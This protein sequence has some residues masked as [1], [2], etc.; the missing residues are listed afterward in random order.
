[1]RGHST[2]FVG[3]GSGGF[4]TMRVLTVV[5][6][7]VANFHAQRTLSERGRV[8]A[9]DCAR[10]LGVGVD[11][12]G[13]R[14]FFVREANRKNTSPRPLPDKSEV[15]TS[16]FTGSLWPGMTWRRATSTPRREPRARAT[17]PY[18]RRD[19]SFLRSE[20]IGRSKS[21]AVTR[22]RIETQS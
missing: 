5:V 13:K 7:A 22:Q 3:L 1:M 19:T 4:V 21:F 20:K 16:C 11:V 17:Q 18:N 9:A 10:P 12:F 15:S 8:G 14:E 2:L 6:K